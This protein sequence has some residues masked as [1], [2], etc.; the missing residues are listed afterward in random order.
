MAADRLLLSEAKA[1]FD[2]IEG[3]KRF[4]ETQD[5]VDDLKKLLPLLLDNDPEEVVAAHYAAIEIVS[6]PTPSVIPFD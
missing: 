2:G 1:L 4:C 5:D 6:A 3:L